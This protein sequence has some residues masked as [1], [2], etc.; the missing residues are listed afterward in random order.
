MCLF[1]MFRNRNWNMNFI[2][3]TCGT[4]FS[5]TVGEPESCPICTDER[6]YVGLEGQHWTTLHDL[7]RDYKTKLQS[8]EPG[9]T[10][11]SM[12][13]KLGIGQRAFLIQTTSGNVL[14]DCISLLDDAALQH[15]RQ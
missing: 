5:D 8:E 13:P 9:V 12:E 3:I 6:Q 11:F 4:Q 10:S 14:W 2:C 1:R 7:R 15:I